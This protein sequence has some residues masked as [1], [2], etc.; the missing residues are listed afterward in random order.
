MPGAK[1]KHVAAKLKQ[2][3]AKPH[4]SARNNTITL[5][6]LLNGKTVVELKE[7]LPEGVTTGRSN[8]A[9]LID[10][11]INA[12]NPHKLQL[13]MIIYDINICG[14]AIPRMMDDRDIIKVFVRLFTSII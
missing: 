5:R 4:E 3:G 12:D 8:K 14:E 11:I 2:L 10:K 7:M 13:G 1:D 6:S 9:E